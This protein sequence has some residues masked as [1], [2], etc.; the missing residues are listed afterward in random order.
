MPKYHAR[1]IYNPA[2]GAF[3]SGL[4][5]EKISDALSV[6]GW[7]FD[8]Q[9]S[10]S[11]KHVTE[12]AFDA[13]TE[14]FD[15][16]FVAGGDGTVNLAAAGLIGS[17]TALGVLPG[18]TANVLAQELGLSSLH[19]IRMANLLDAAR[20]LIAGR[21]QEID[22]GFCNERPFLLWAGIGLDG[23]IIHRI[24][25]RKPWEKQLSVIT[26]A[27][28]AV[29]NI[30][31]WSGVYLQ[32]LSP[33][34]VIEG[35]FLMAVAS[36]IRLYA[37]GLAELSPSACLDDGVMDLWLFEGKSPI[38]AYQRAIDVFTKR[39]LTSTNFRQIPFHSLIIQSPAPLYT[40]LDAE[41]FEDTGPI[42]LRVQPRALK[43]IVPSTAKKEL[44]MQPPV[45]RYS[46]A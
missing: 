9:E 32:V 8:V 45:F 2:A 29:W 22:V 16:V 6:Y 43:L 36:N 34:E 41:P 39:H 24:E 17:K 21:V 14:G 31:F 25:P 28:R 20:K 44:F 35:S 4:I 5:S 38:E 30:H 19:L 37:G 27:S 33:K 40:Q 23:F 10:K 12:L 15:A 7:A 11:S 42:C 3:P 46:E 26:Y 18:G 13:A 1:I